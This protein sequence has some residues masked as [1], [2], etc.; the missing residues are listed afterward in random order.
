M[1]Y[2]Y[3]CSAIIS[4]KAN[5]F[6]IAIVCCIYFAPNNFS[7]RRNWCEIRYGDSKYKIWGC[8]LN[9]GTNSFYKI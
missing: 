8:F 6:I 5:Y 3:N 9:I 2:Y 1:A 4:T 7:E